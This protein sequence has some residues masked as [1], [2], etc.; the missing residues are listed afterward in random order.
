M[1][2]MRIAVETWGQSVNLPKK[3]NLRGL[4]EG[5][6]NCTPNMKLI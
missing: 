6:N 2:H 3:D 4:R 1:T 5:N